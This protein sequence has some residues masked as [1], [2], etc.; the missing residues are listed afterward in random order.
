MELNA[1]VSAIKVII[2][3][4][5]IHLI[6]NAQ[7]VMRIVQNVMVQILMNVTVVLMAFIT[8]LLE[9]TIGVILAILLVI[10]V[11]T[12]V[13][14]NVQNVILDTFL[15]LQAPVPQHVLIRSME[16]IELM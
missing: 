16:T 10:F 2:R 8:M 1:R 14:I 9:G 7:N 11:L 3:I 6:L 12:V 4:I 15:I 13:I 5:Q